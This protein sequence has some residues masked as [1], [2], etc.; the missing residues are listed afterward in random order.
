MTRR[1]KLRT[2]RSVGNVFRDLGFAP[3]KGERLQVRADL[4]IRIEKDL[5][6]RRLTQ[7]KAAELLGVTQPRVT[8]LL[9]GRVVQSRSISRD[10]RPHPIATQWWPNL[11]HCAVQT[12]KGL[13]SLSSRVPVA[14][15]PQ[16]L[17]SS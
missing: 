15:L 1:A 16:R 11:L 6:S 17:R 14:E 4:M 7:A 2:T 9:R 12:A 13:L 5:V 8:D 10:S 3:G